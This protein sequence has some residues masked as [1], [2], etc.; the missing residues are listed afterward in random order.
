[1]NS[2]QAWLLV[3]G[4]AVA[5]PSA[6]AAQGK[7]GL[8]LG[9]DTGVSVGFL[10]NAD[11]AYSDN[12]VFTLAVPDANLRMGLLVGESAEIEPSVS[13]VYVSQGQRSAGQVGL[14]FHYLHNMG[15]DHGVR[16]FLKAG[17]LCQG[18]VARGDSF[19]AGFSVG[20]GLRIGSD[21]RLRARLELEIARLF[22]ED[23]R[24]GLW[25]IAL[26]AGFSVYAP[27]RS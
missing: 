6:S 17:V 20:G 9:V 8:E 11:R 27:P 24:R 12:Q 5:S 22:R 2:R 25:Q 14:G 4:L 3:V 1:M 18:Y 19:Q 16:R 7:G 21:P 13:L 26:R 10:D 23:F 15:G